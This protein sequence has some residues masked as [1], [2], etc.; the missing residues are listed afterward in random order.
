MKIAL[1]GPIAW[2]TPPRHYGPWELI[3]SLL[4]EGLTER[5]VDVTLFATL[6]SVTKAA[7]DGVV[8]TGYEE[9]AAIDGRVWEAIHVSHALARSG[10]FDLIH[11]HLDW[12]PLAFSAHSRAPMLTTVH[13]FSGNNILPAYARARSHFVSIS[14]ADRS[15][16]LD[17]LATV[18]HGVDLTGLPFQADAGDDLIIFGRIHPDKGTDIAI[19]IARR[20]GRRLVI[21]GIVQD[22]DYFAE[23]VE[24]LIDGNRVVYLGSV[25]PQERGAILGSSAALLHPIRFAEPFG[26]SVV[27]SM[28]CGTPVVA[29]RKGSMPEVV[30]DGVTGR[31]VDS[32]DE[33]VAAV[34]GI[35]AIDRAGCSARARERFSAERMVDEYLAIYRKI[36]S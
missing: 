3:T 28:A 11:N 19:E 17:Y 21:C 2:R 8:P 24:P 25:G 18:H 26:L 20:A 22:R 9:S 4:A 5:G 23:C 12:L 30:D 33:A 7:L 36:V 1:L 14:D 35:A 27:E 16:D 13:G 6:D 31:L 15:P 34:Q 29:Y 10:E 32:V